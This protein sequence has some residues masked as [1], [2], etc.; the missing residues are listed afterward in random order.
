MRNICFYDSVCL[1]IRFLLNL[2]EA[3]MEFHHIH[4]YMTNHV[5]MKK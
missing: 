4:I 1:S 3:L 5:I 2:E